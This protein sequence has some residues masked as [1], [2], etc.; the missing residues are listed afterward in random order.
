MSL[1]G[2]SERGVVTS[3]DL[4]KTFWTPSISQKW[5]KLELSNF[6]HREIISSLAK[7]MTNHP[8]RGVVWLTQ[9]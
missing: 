6:V 4:F 8:E 1:K 9:L 2:V 7:V 3:H 5:L